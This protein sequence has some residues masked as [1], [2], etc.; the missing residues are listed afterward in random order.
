MSEMQ[1][2]WG[3]IKCLGAQRVDARV[4]LGWSAGFDK[5]VKTIEDRQLETF[6]EEIK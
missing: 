6:S 5:A 4:F 1:K 2:P 3:F